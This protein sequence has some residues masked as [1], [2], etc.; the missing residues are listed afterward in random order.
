MKTV[1]NDKAVNTRIPTS[2]WEWL[3]SFGPAGRILNAIAYEAERA[4][5]FGI[6]PYK[7]SESISDLQMIRRRS[8]AE[9][10][11]IFTPAEWMLMADSLNGTIA[12]ADFRCY[13]SALAANIEDSDKFDNIGA[14]WNVDVKK[15]IYKIEDLTAAQVDAVFARVEAFWDSEEKDLDKWAEW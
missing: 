8:E 14:K 9:L 10:K 5:S 12:S 3:T 13:P 15:L 6:P 4:C 2:T 1:K 7:I 11:G